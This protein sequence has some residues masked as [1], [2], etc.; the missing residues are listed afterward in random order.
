LSAAASERVRTRS[1]HGDSDNDN[2]EL[3]DDDQVD[4]NVARRSR[5]LRWASNAASSATAPSATPN[6]EWGGAGTVSTISNLAVILQLFCDTTID[7][8]FIISEIG[9]IVTMN[10]AA[11]A[12]FQYKRWEVV[13]RNVTMLME[14]KYARAHDSFLAR[15]RRT[16]V[17][18]VIGEERDG[19]FAMRK[20]G[21]LFRMLL[22]VHEYR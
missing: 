10:A 8:T 17:K 22:K 21:N 7:A 3:D 18:R 4:D 16:R 20:D 13:G 6:A 19:L 2:D 15:Y 1:I 12:L 5:P 11:L 14:P 9:A